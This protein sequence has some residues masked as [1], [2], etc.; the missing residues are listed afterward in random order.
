MCFILLV[1]ASKVKEVVNSALGGVL[2]IAE[3]YCLINIGVPN[4]FG[5]EVI[6]TLVK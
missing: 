5:L 3:A 6:D 1:A 4:D 2:F